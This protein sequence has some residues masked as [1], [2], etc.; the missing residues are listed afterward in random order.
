MQ[1]F[2]ETE[3]LILRRFTPDDVDA[4]YE[5]DSDPEVMRHVTGGQGTPRDAI[6]DDYIPAYLRYYER[7][8]GYGFWA[9]I[10]RSSGDF[11]GWFHFRP[12]PDRPP[13]E[14]E[15]GY[16][17][18]RAA[19]GRG[20][21]TEG[22]RA[23]IDHGFGVLGVRRVVASAGADNI[24]SWRVMEKC[25]LIRVR[26]YRVTFPDLFDGVEQED[27]EYALTRDEWARQR[28]TCAESP[29]S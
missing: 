23:L 12:L 4:L 18:R 27:V 25:G 19:W 14:P 17:L 22:S 20:L 15:L 21:A 29:H 9:A 11:L 26:T 16:R 3:R 6:R 2:L 24:A 13:D 10:E 8:T 28:A 7:F 1:I 5:L